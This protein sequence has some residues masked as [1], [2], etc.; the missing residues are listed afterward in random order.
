[1][2]FLR[3]SDNAR[4]H[5]N[6]RRILSGKLWGDLLRM[7]CQSA[8]REAYTIIYFAWTKIWAPISSNNYFSG[9]VWQRLELISNNMVM[10]NLMVNFL[11]KTVYPMKN[12]WIKSS[13]TIE[14]E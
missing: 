1:V 3:W 5:H 6:E 14:W 11:L 13:C 8:F 4:T 9:K 10:V 7:Q 12:N 2:P